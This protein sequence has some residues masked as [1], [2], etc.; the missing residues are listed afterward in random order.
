M[1]EWLGRWADELVTTFNVI[2]GALWIG[3]GI[4]LFAI[5]RTQPPTA[6]VGLAAAI[7]FVSYGLSDFAEIWVGSWYRP[8]W[9]L[10]W[11][12]T[13][14]TAIFLSLLELARRSAKHKRG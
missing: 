4:R 6:K 7:C 12:S 8:W 14:F 2:E 9:M 13:S 1:L 11:K 3:I 5:H 10:A